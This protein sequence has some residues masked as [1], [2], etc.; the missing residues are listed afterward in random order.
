MKPGVE[1]LETVA[2]E[3]GKVRVLIFRDRRDGVYHW[4]ALE[5]LRPSGEWDEIVRVGDRKLQEAIDLFTRA[6][7]FVKANPPQGGHE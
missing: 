6:R 2:A 7:D 3:N 5:F 1:L 4:Y